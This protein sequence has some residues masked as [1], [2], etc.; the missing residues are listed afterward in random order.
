MIASFVV[1]LTSYNGKYTQAAV[2][3]DPE[4]FYKQ[5]CTSKDIIIYQ[6][7]Y[8]YFCTKAKTATGGTKYKTIGFNISIKATSYSIGCATAKTIETVGSKAVSS[9]GYTYTL[10]KVDYMNM[11]NRFIDRY[12][13]DGYFNNMLLQSKSPIFIF[14]V[15]MTVTEDGS[16]QGS[17]TE[18]SNGTITGKGEVYQSASG[19]KGATNW[20]TP[21]DLDQ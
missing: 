11:V 8:F 5:Y 6:E 15:I 2:T 10:F 1:F 14:N 3:Q 12:G 7:G 20:G 4:V 19:I 13:N 18:N 21:G 16:P 17:I 9:E